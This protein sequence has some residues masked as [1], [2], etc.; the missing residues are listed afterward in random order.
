MQS[1]EDLNKQFDSLRNPHSEGRLDV[2]WGGLG[3]ESYRIAGGIDP[4]QRGRL[5]AL[6]TIAGKKLL[7]RAPLDTPE[8]DS[9]P[10]PTLRWLKAV[11]HLSGLFRMGMY[12]H[13]LDAEGNQ[14][15]TIFNG[16]VDRFEEASAVLC[17]RL[18]AIGDTDLS[19][20]NTELPDPRR[21][22]VVH[23]RDT[24]LR[25]DFFAFLRALDLH[26]IEWS[27]AI[28]LTGKGSPYVGETLDAAFEDAQAI[29]VLLTPDDIVRLHPTLA[30]AN[31]PP[32]ESIDSLQARPN[33]LFEAG[34]AFGRN[35]S[36]T[37]L[38]EVGNVKRFSD[39]G[40][41]HTVRLT[42]DPAKRQDLAD[43]LTTAGCKVV[44]RSQDWL[45]TG[46]FSVGRAP[47]LPALDPPAS[48]EEP[49][50]K[51]VDLNYPADSGLQGT[52]EAEGYRVKWC[53]DDNLARSLDIDGWT[54]VTQQQGNGRATI[55]KIKDYPDNHTLVKKRTTPIG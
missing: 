41:R 25:L 12:G 45:K 50:I 10:D 19:S 3:G 31:D 2:S 9:E 55:L 44:I 35:P 48:Q 21:V 6:S 54:L 17:L 1:W 4:Y 46:D 14:L 32:E 42:N 38:V 27:E 26:P 37:I 43:R 11:R 30:A 39:V 8:V 47:A 15:S 7:A 40:G 23:G 29:V 20:I 33:V 36:R 52:L 53:M 51:W 49:L 22:F 24:K 34:M 28:A 5:E 18:A 13:E 16:T